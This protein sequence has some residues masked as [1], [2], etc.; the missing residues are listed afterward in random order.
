M[1]SL[2][3]SRAAPNGSSDAVSRATFVG[4]AILM[5]LLG[6]IVVEMFLMLQEMRQLGS[7]LPNSA[8]SVDRL[9]AVKSDLDRMQPDLHQVNVRMNQIQTNTSGLNTSLDDLAAKMA[10]LDADLVQVKAELKD[11]D[12]HVANLDRKTGPAPPGGIP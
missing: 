12:Q 9:D 5:V 2:T 1:A 10:A 7:S 11:I 3:R 4:A 8:P 6:A